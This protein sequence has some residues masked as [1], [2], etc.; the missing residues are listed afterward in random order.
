MNDLFW[1]KNTFNIYILYIVVVWLL[2]IPLIFWNITLITVWP[3]S[4][5]SWK[6]HWTFKYYLTNLWFFFEMLVIP[7]WLSTI[8]STNYKVFKKWVYVFEMPEQEKC[9]IYYRDNFKT[10]SCDSHRCLLNNKPYFAHF[11]LG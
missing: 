1:Q 2:Y 5:G 3:P 7:F 8:L 10:Y 11:T 9:S 4:W 6:C